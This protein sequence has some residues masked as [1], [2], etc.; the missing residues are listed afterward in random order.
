M[1]KIEVV[2][3]GRDSI[4]FLAVVLSYKEIQQRYFL[5]HSIKS[6]SPFHLKKKKKKKKKERKQT[7]ENNN[8][9]IIVVSYMWPVFCLFFLSPASGTTATDMVL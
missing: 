3:Q 7:H 4:V 9:T 5:L 8:H 2:G 1:R 6:S